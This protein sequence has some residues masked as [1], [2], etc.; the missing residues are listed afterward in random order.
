MEAGIREGKDKGAIIWASVLGFVISAAVI[1]LC[2][3]VG[4]SGPWSAMGVALSMWIGGPLPVIVIN[5]M[6]VKFDP[7]ITFA[8]AL[9]YLARMVIAGVAAG[10]ALPLS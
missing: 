9:G 6:F 5:G 7:K 3:L 2:A 4:I 1:A 10:I 8:H